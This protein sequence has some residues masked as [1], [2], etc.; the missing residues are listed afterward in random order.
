MYMI[1]IIA[2]ANLSTFLWV[3]GGCKL[4]H[5]H[6]R[7]SGVGDMHCDLFARSVGRIL[8]GHSVRAPPPIV[9]LNHLYTELQLL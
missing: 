7:S 3:L 5:T 8:T 1:A 6:T 2:N 9:V 4:L